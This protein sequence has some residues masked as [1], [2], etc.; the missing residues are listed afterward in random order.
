LIVT[1]ARCGILHAASQNRDHPD[2]M[3]PQLP[4]LCSALCGESGARRCIRGTHTR[5]EAIW[6]FL[7]LSNLGAKSGNFRDSAIDHWSNST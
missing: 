6:S 1:R 7:L 3:H 5:D 2:R 4:R